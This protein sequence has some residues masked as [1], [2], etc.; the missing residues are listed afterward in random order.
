MRQILSI[1]IFFVTLSCTNNKYREPPLF[2]DLSSD[3]V[4]PKH[5]VVTK[6]A[7]QIVIDGI[8]NEASWQL[9][10]FSESFIDIEGVIKP[11]FDTKIK[12]LWDE[13]YLYVFSQMQE[14][15]IWGNLKQRDTVIYFNNDFEIFIDPSGTGKNYAE[16][17]INSLGT[18]WDLLL[19]KP[20][21]VGGKVNNYWNLNE[22]RAAVKIYGSI[23]NHHDIDSLWTVEMA[24]PMK[25]LTELKDKPRTLP[26]E[27]EQ[28]RINFSRVEWDY[29]IINGSYQ[30]KKE[31]G[32][33]LRE[34][35]WVWSNQKTINMHEPE[36]WGVLQ[37][38][39][40]PS[41]KNIKF[42]EDENM[43]TKQI[44]FALFRQTNYGSLKRLWQEDIGTTQD[45]SVAY[46]DKETLNVTFYKTNFGFEFKIEAPESEQVY[47]INQEG[48][49]KTLK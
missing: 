41:S 16:I 43:L 27:G 36:K 33:F 21:R 9:A 6:N 45:F 26:I 24:I 7:E 22:L 12:M 31:N 39:N 13:N 1:L 38:T 34:Y 25:P 20:Y 11:K 44:A 2:I 29:D 8:A 40:E 15:H 49:L 23:N 32:E 17:E 37:F 47:I 10:A 14:P 28:W 19:D 30:R 18:L 3:I 48:V 5:Y 35:N 46:S 4:V 42:I